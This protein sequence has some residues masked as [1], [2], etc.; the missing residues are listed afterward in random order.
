[1][2]APP[3]DLLALARE[4][5]ELRQQLGEAEELIAAIRTG[6]VDALAVQNA[7]G[8]RIFTLEGADQGYR[9]LI[10]QMHEGAVLLSADGTM[11]YCNAGLAQLLDSEPAGM[12]GRPFAGF[13]PAEFATYWQ[14]LSHLAWAD[15]AKGELPLQTPTGHLRPCAVSMNKLAFGGTLVL[16][17]LVTDISAQ[18]EVT[19]IRELVR[20]QDALLAHKTAELARQ[21][22]A[23]REV[24]QAAAEARRL[25]EGIPQIAWTASP[26]GHNTYLNQRWFDYTGQQPRWPMEAQLLTSIHPDDLTLAMAYWQ[27]SM[28]SGQPLELECRIR[29]RAGHFR[30]M[31]GRALPMR[32]EQGHIVQ[33]VGTYT[34]I[35][36]HKMALQRLDE[37]QQELRRNNEQLTRANVDLD[38][39]VYTASH[40]LK[41]PITNV[42]G[43]LQALLMELPPTVRDGTEVRPLLA[44]M[45]DSVDR[46]QHTIELLTDVSRLQRTLAA[47]TEPVDLVAVVEA[48]RLDLLPLIRAGGAQ[49]ETDLAACPEVIF[50]EKNLRSVVYNLL[51]NALKYH[52]PNRSPLV[53]ISSRA[54]A[55]HDVLSVQDNGLGLDPT[56]EERIYGMFQRLHD[57]VDGSGIGLY[58][59]KKM[60]ENA[61][62]HLV[63]RSVPGEG[64][65]FEVHFLR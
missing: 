18:D 43:L 36:E 25:L 6:A 29:N 2:P 42:E 38:N 44:M 23:Q 10:E 20:E 50:S 31:L 52:H 59:V 9:N 49:I 34:D 16:A 4:N 61:G 1:M 55:R 17:V 3:T 45:Q 28:A 8:P 64:A 39:F 46:F 5:E 62:G 24:E 32:D 53:Y 58:M 19:S 40:D 22:V 26:D 21:Q 48:V 65:T 51:S 12:T 56:Q 15:K 37:T 14:S 33:W 57:H 54:E 11:L 63:L 13:V 35:H 47:P 60:V 27:K 41:A 7:D 30:W